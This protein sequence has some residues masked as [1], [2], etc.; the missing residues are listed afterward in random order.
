[1]SNEAPRVSERWL[2]WLAAP[3]WCHALWAMVVMV[4]F[5]LAVPAAVLR[6]PYDPGIGVIYLGGTVWLWITRYRR[7]QEFRRLDRRSRLVVARTQ[8]TGLTSGDKRLDHIARDR[9]IT[10]LNSAP[11]WSDPVAAYVLPLVVAAVFVAAAVRSS[12]WWLA[13]LPL[14]IVPLVARSWPR[15]HLDRQLLLEKLNTNVELRT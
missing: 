11:V 7:D 4:P 1:M 8:Y 9:L 14:T 3:A 13:A 10:S 15:R 12:P 6:R 2:S 5:V